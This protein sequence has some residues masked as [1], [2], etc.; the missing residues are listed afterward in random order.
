[1]IVV[2]VVVIDGDSRIRYGDG[3]LRSGDHGSGIHRR[4]FCDGGDKDVL[5][6]IAV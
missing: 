6:I 1:M 4:R 5:E 3:H 2:V